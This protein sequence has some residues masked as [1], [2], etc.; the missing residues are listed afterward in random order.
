MT[1]PS[2]RPKH[3]NDYTTCRNKLYLG[4]SE[5]NLEYDA[6]HK[7]IAQRKEWIGVRC[8]EEAG[9]L[10][11]ILDKFHRPSIS[12]NALGNSFVCSDFNFSGRKHEHGRLG[13][14][15]SLEKTSHSVAY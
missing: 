6:K 8:L 10:T 13:K 5:V 12:N 1:I 11:V 4:S 14:L 9:M 15:P 3:G 7:S 2:T